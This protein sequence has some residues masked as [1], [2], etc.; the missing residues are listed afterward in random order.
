MPGRRVALRDGSNGARASGPHECEP[1]ANSACSAGFAGRDARAPLQDYFGLAS[2]K[3][4]SFVRT[5]SFG[6]P[7]GAWT[8]TLILCHLPSVVKSFG[9]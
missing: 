7:L 1:R 3:Y 2:A 6:N 9:L 5:N 8:D 4:P